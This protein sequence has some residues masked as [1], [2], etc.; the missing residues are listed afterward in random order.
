MRAYLRPAVSTPAFA[1][2]A[3]SAVA[4]TACAS[5][6]VPV[7]QSLPAS[8]T[9]AAAAHTTTASGRLVDRDSNAPLRGV[10]VWLRA[11]HR[12]AHARIVTHTNSRGR[13]SFTA[14]NGHY[15]LLLGSN[16]PNDTR[17][18][19]HDQIWLRGGSQP[20]AAPTAWP[21]PDVTPPAAERSGAYRLMKLNDS[22]LPCIA[23]VNQHRNALKLHRAV[24]DEWLEENSYE[25]DRSQIRQGKVGGPGFITEH[26]DARGGSARATPSCN[27]WTSSVFSAG[28][29]GVW[30]LYPM[31]VSR[32]LIWYGGA[33]I[34]NS[35]CDGK[36]L[37]T[38]FES[39]G[40]DPTIDH[41]CP[42]PSPNPPP[43]PV[44]GNCDPLFT[45]W[46]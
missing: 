35:C 13:F 16:R 18:T 40:Y 25:Y 19:V 15:L 20:L 31:A 42:S 26:E 30:S 21:V 38:G 41:A 9:Y 43:P 32:G 44:P 1:V 34:L 14:E 4:L 10:P 27:V 29:Y 45:A 24:P 17:A 37:S 5:Q 33:L 3:L 23:S 46:P 12:H 8:Q 36:K 7:R 22:Q 6:T 28:T 39:W 2:C 11:W